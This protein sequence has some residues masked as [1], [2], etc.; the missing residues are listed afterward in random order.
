MLNK[1]KI[2]NRIEAVMQGGTTADAG[3]LGGGLSVVAELYGA[4]VCLRK[5]AY[6]KG[7]LK[8]RRLDCLVV[9][10]GNLTLGGTGKTP[11][12]I[13]L[14][15]R[16][17][18][19]G[20]RVVVISRGYRGSAERKGGVA[21]N[22]KDIL[23]Q[24]SACGDE[25]YMMARAL[26]DIPV[27]VG[28]DRYAIGRVALQKFSPQVIL[29]DDAFQHIR[30]WRDLDLVLLD[31]GKPFGNEKLFPSGC[32]AGGERRFAPNQRGCPHTCWKRCRGCF[33][34]CRPV[35]T[36]EADISM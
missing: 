9:S 36:G 16:I 35:C 12:T 31:A 26:G 28:R 34:R 1:M 32:P 27:M 19:Y 10:V 7:W 15:R 14:A 13:Y 2:R 23:M 29:L 21:S 3:W 20:Y 8:T 11:A 6:A 5:T 22:G 30:L 4:G 17:Q 18:S 24:A 33:R 25:A